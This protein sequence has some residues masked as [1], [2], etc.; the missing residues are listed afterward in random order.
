MT[1]KELGVEGFNLNCL[2]KFKSSFYGGSWSCAQFDFPAR[3]GIKIDVIKTRLKALEKCGILN[4]SHKDFIIG[5]DGLGYGRIANSYCTKN[6]FDF[7]KDGEA[8]RPYSRGKLITNKVYE[9]L[10]GMFNKDDN[11][12]LWGSKGAA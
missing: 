9:K 12:G 5:L 2:I 10:K 7:V 1:R 6:F 3:T 11:E 8:K 4:N